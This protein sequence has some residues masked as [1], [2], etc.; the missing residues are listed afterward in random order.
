MKIEDKKLRA[1][2]ESVRNTVLKDMRIDKAEAL[3]LLAFARSLS[4]TYKEMADFAKLLEKVLADGKV[5]QDESVQVGAYLSWL[6]KE[7]EPGG[8]GGG[9]L[10]SALQART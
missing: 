2:I 1:T 4:L 6:A 7:D 8:Q 5:T 9:L 3:E 10:R